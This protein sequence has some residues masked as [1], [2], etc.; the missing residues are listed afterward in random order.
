MKEIISK[1]YILKNCYGI[2]LT[3]HKRT[4]WFIFYLVLGLILSFFMGLNMG[5][6]DV[7]IQDVFSVL[8]GDVSANNATET[9]YQFRLPRVVSSMCA[10]ALMALSGY[11]LQI[12]SHNPLADPSVLGLTSG[13]TLVAIFIYFLMPTL[14]PMYATLA[15]A[16]GAILTG[17]L[18]LCISRKRTR[19]VFIL[20]VGIAI[21]TAFSSITEILLASLDMENM[22]SVQVMLAGSFESITLHGMKFLLWVTVACLVIFF[23][24]GRSINPLALGFSVAQ[25]LGVSSKKMMVMMIM[26]AI[27]CMAPVIALVGAMSFI[28]LVSTFFAK[29]IIGYRGNE[30]GI[31]SMLIGAIITTWADTLGRTLFAPIMIHAGVFVACIGAFLFVIITRYMT[32]K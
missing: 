4:F 24:L 26:L 11:M 21:G 14:P 28:G 30:L 27:A 16:T 9:I 23:T 3:I 2:S 7:T 1:N 5:S 8:R 15:T 29:N 6:I 13:A 31:V 25:T 19:G 20:L 22:V 10:G 32:V 12:M 17:I 18:I